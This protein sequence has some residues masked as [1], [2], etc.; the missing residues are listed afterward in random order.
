MYFPEFERYSDE[1]ARLL[2]RGWY[3]NHGPLAQELETR[4][5]DFF[6][7]DHAIVV[8]NA[9]IGL[10]MVLKA[11]INVEN[12]LVPSFTFIASAQS[13]TWCGMRPI[14]C[15]VDLA[16]HQL[17]PESV[18]S[19][20]RHNFDAIMAVNLW[21]GT[22]NPSAME[23]FAR[24]LN[25]PL[26]FDS[27]QAVGV[28]FGGRRLG[29]FGAA[30]VFSFHATKIVNATEGG[31]VTT[32]DA[33]LAARLRNIRSSYGAGP[34]VEVPV[35]ANGRFSEAQAAI[36]LMSLEDFPLNRE[37]NLGQFAR[38]RSALEGITGI[39]L[40]PPAACTE[41][42]HQYVV[43]DVA[44]E[45]FG[46][47]RD[48]LIR[49]LN[50]E[51][52]LARRYFMPGVHRSPPYVDDRSHDGSRF[53]ATEKLSGTLLQLPIG[54]LVDDTAIEIVVDLIREAHVR[55]DAVSRVVRQ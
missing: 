33:D 24:E 30:E 55:C 31:C 38:Y 4:L 18:T 51:R 53:R 16:T 2:E 20:V 5:A 49:V 34:P 26:I 40:V 27:A 41:S 7:V 10:M 25:V 32:N 45:E 8:A 28:R 37:R 6:E 50:A 9:T 39:R 11:L 36:A 19:S 14:L 44:E 47:S 29:S 3:T 35:T 52:V 43:L 46:L 54:S 21:G 22:C 1:M 42:N 12:V 15:D 48:E 23:E 13:I 17:S